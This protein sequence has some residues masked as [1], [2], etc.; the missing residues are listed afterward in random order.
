M[1]VSSM[2]TP[3]TLLAPHDWAVDMSRRCIL[4]NEQVITYFTGDPTLVATDIKHA[5]SSK[6]ILWQDG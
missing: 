3:I 5:T 2:S 1:S 6:C 4:G